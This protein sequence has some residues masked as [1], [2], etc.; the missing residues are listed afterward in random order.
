[1]PRARDL[2]TGALA[3]AR[4]LETGTLEERLG[5]EPFAPHTIEIS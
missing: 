4:L 3:A 2:I 5:L 1:M